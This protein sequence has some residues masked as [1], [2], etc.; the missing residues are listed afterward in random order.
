MKVTFL[1]TGTSQGVP[2][3]G[4]QCRVC[5]SEDPR[6]KRLRSSVMIE[7]NGSVFVIDSGPDFR[8]QMLREKV[9]RLDAVIF[10]HEHKD[11]IAGL[12]DVRAFNYLHHR[13]MDV[14]ASERVQSALR[15]EFAYIFSGEEYP[16]I[17]KIN[18]HTIHD[19]TPFRVGET[20]FQP[21]EVLH[22]RLPVLGFRIGGFSYITDANFIAEEE[23]E[24]IRNSDVLVI[25]ALR[26]EKHVSHF[27]LEEATQLVEE[28]RPGNAYLIHISH[29]LGRHE[30]IEKELPAGIHCA[31]DGLQLRIN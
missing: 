11:H 9:T 6:D 1:G 3:I 30:E 21:V 23:K 26:R 17:P 29:Q 14:Y 22:Y 2:L 10:T 20:E 5:S 19:S 13:H 28:L 7:D 4:C 31:Y 16:G 18:L 25:N 8:Q 27:S 15:R 12:D 24:K